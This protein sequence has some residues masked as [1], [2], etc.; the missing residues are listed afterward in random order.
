MKI[1]R[2]SPAT[3]TPLIIAVALLITSGLLAYSYSTDRWPFKNATGSSGTE[4][5]GSINYNPPTDQ[6]IAEGQDAKK[7]GEGLSEQDRP[8][9][10][11]EG[12]GKKTA[13]DVGI[14][15]ADVYENNL[16]IRAFTNGTIEGTGTCTATVTMKAS[17]FTKIT[18]QSKAF[19]DTSTTQCQPIYIPTSELQ[20]GA[21]DVVVSFSSPDHEGTSDKVE[22]TI[23]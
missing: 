15:F 5:P 6:E 3:K 9:E 17:P 1:Q 4:E 10:Q 20:A 7:R 16:E 13:V 2:Y 23:P 14:S 19:I 12:T 8:D 11:S 22:V 21:W 18:K